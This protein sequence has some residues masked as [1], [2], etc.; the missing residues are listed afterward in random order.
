MK[1]DEYTHHLDSKIGRS[2]GIFLAHFGA[3]PISGSNEID[4]VNKKSLYYND[5][6]K[7]RP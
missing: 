1:I 6:S 5:L 4:K 7:E 2:E 3:P